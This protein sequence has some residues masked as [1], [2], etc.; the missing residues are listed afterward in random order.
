V[1]V[2]DQGQSWGWLSLNSVITYIVV[3]I[4]FIFFIQ[5]EKK[6]QEPVVD[7][8]FFA[9]PTFSA[10]IITSF[11]T[12]MGLMGC[13]FITPIFI[14]NYLGYSVTKTGLLF[15]PMAMGMMIA[16]PIGGKLSTKIEPRYIVFL[17]F[18]RIECFYFRNDLN[19]QH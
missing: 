7:L 13:M 4:S 14:Q 16:A 17:V 18:L 1:T 15:I 12:F 19:G 10:A 11:I 6:A 2:L 5:V 9:I 8:K 3:I